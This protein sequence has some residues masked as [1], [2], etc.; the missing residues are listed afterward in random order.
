MCSRRIRFMAVAVCCEARLVWRAVVFISQPPGLPP[1]VRLIAS[2]STSGPRSNWGKF[3]GW[4]PAAITA[5][6]FRVF[7]WLAMTA[8]GLTGLAEPSTW[9]TTTT[10]SPTSRC[11]LVV[12]GGASAMYILRNRLQLLISMVISMVTTTTS[13]V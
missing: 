11:S 4:R 5:Y 13:I 10:R 2:V 7:S 1:M 3:I 9:C 6:R 12:R 8:L